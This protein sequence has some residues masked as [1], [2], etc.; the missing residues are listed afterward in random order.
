MPAWK[1]W[2]GFAAR[3][4]GRLVVDAGARKAVETK[5]RSLLPIGV[6]QVV[7]TFGK[8]DVVALCDSN[9]VEFA[10]GL[11]NYASATVDRLRGLRSDQIPEALGECPYEE[12]VHKDNLVVTV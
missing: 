4:K 3:P 12:V 9:G 6:V 1:R 11:T 8:G 5:N 2:L 10:R 7:G